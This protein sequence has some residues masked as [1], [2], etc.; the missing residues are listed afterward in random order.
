MEIG[1][2]VFRMVGEDAGLGVVGGD[3]KAFL[4][5][6][7]AADLRGER[8][9]GLLHVGEVAVDVEVVGIHRGDDGDLREELQ[10]GTVEFIGLGHDGGRVADEGVGVVI[11]GD[12]AEECR[13]ALAAFGENVRREGAGGRLAV[14]AGD[15]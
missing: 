1:F 2:P 5:D 14:R 7:G 3:R 12:A 15:G 6:D 4:D 11:A 10:E 9:E 13:A 8:L